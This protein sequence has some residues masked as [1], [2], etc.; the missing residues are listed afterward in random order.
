MKI[1]INNN[2]KLTYFS[3]TYLITETTNQLLIYGS[4]N[5]LSPSIAFETSLYS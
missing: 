1:Y 2:N 5:K 3:I 4:L